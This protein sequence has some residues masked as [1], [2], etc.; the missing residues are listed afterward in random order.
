MSTGGGLEGR[1]HGRGVVMERAWSNV[2]PYCYRFSVADFT[3]NPDKYIKYTPRDV[4][5]K[6]SKFF[7]LG[8]D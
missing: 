8:A 7:D 3:K 1:G 4:E 6:I 2:V 5:L